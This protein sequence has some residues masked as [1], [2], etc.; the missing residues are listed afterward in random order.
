M[1]APRENALQGKRVIFVL[2]EFTLGG[3]ERQ[4]LLLARLLRQRAGAHVEVWSVRG[5]TGRVSQ[6]CDELGLPWKTLPLEWKPSRPA[7]LRDLARL[8][9]ALRGAR[10][11]IVMPYITFQNVA[12]GLIWRWTG[13]RL[14]VWNQREEGIIRLGG[15]AELG[16]VRRVPLF[17]SNSQGGA[18]FLKRELKAS[19]ERVHVVHNGVELAPPELTREQWR[20]GCAVRENDFAVGMI[21]NFNGY[22]DHLTLLRAWRLVV[23]AQTEGQ[24]AVLLFAGKTDGSY[25]APFQAAR[26]LCDELEL[27]DH[28]RFLGGV[29]DIAG[30]TRALDAGAFC[31]HSEGVPNGVL[32]CMASGLAVVGSDIPGVREALGAPGNECLAPPE[33]PAR[34]AELLLRLQQ[35]E[36]WRLRLGD[37]N[38]S[39]IAREFSSEALFE[40]TVQ[41]LARGLETTR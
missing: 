31:S 27:S 30:L 18:D 13:A 19:P 15:R 25:T 38:R 3:A 23:E 16:A 14:C 40:C 10:P 7:L 1:T 9:L 32:E 26:A 17:I 29:N 36:N 6:L 35:D 2:G 28:V 37:E 34:L 4:S 20:A 39:R 33:D 8:T 12:C 24:N 22:K 11:D 41:L 5:Q 21:A